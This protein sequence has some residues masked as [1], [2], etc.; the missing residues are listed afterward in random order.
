MHRLV[1]F[2][3]GLTLAVIP[4]PLASNRDW[5]W[6]PLAAVAG[7]LLLGAAASLVLQPDS[8]RRFMANMPALLVPGLLAVLGLGWAAVQISGW[9]PENWTTSISAASVLGPEVAP[10][11]V[12]FDRE[13]VLTGLMRLL[14]NI[15][16]FL[17]G[18]IFG[19]HTREARRLLATIVIAASLYT[20]YAMAAQV[21][22]SQAAWT[23]V[24]LWV[25]SSSTSYFTGTFINP[26]NYS[27]YA[28][29][30][31]VTALCLALKPR[32]SRDGESARQ[33]W[34][35]RLAMLT[36]AGALWLAVALVL[37]VG[38]LLAGSKAGST[39]LALSL[40]AMAFIY[41]R[42]VRRILAIFVT[43]VLMGVAVVALPGARELVARMV[44][45]ATHGDESREIL[46]SMTLQAIA[47]RP[48]TGW[49][50]NSFSSVYQMLQPDSLSAYYDKAH[51]TYLELAFDLG[52]PAAAALVL[53]VVWIVAR[54]LRGFF[55][56][57]RDPELAGV[58]FLVAVLAGFH[59]LF[60]FSLQ[61]PAMACTFF[62]ILG[63]AWAQSWTGR[64]ADEAGR[65]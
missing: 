29:I 48:L 41:T 24:R 43:L 3:F 7:L 6:S 55:E 25:P 13:A 9:T 26:N 54:C 20:L 64:R 62:A 8:A 10:H 65:P 45:F 46:Y 63:I 34:R 51:N 17:L 35:R 15:A 60:D 40:L 44:S 58:G 59:A 47:L 18:V 39:S 33:A 31:A 11:T 38:A 2:L 22:S 30:T 56:R 36:G 12:A 32:Q 37:L 53:A 21:V 27:T 23:G 49:G 50:L 14:T 52:I 5:A 28:G 19:S 42:G 57:G 16:F 1:L 4:A 61:I